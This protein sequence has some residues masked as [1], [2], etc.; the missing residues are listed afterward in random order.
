[1]SDRLNGITMYSTVI[2]ITGAVHLATG[3]LALGFAPAP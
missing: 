3:D 2:K 1:M